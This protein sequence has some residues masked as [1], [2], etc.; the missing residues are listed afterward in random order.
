MRRSGRLI[1]W[2]AL[3]D[4]QYVGWCEAFNFYQ[5]AITLSEVCK[6]ALLKDGKELVIRA[7]E[8]SNA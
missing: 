8:T 5:A 3:V 1:R 2:I 4:G 7:E 6:A